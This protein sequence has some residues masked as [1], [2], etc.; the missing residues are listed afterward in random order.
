MGQEEILA[1]AGINLTI[2]DNDFIAIVGPSGSGKSTMMNTLGCL[3]LPSSGTYLLND[4]NVGNLSDDELSSLRVEQIG[5]VFQNYNLLSR[6]TAINNV[7]LPLNYSSK[8]TRSERKTLSL[9]TLEKVGLSHRTDHKPYE[10][11]GGEQQRVGIARA[12][13]NNPKILLADEP[14][15]NLDSKTSM[16]IIHL[17]N[18]LNQDGITIVLVTHDEEIADMAKRV[19]SFRD[20]IIEKERFN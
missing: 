2:N 12:L 17:L 10:L 11:S 14:T 6:E 15:G 3:D 7:L 8:Y 19:I 5:F 18:N 4:I 1:L 16:E 9:K 13:V 20:G